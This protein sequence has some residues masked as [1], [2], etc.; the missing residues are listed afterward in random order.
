MV[1]G[2]HANDENKKNSEMW[3]NTAAVIA[4]IVI[5]SL[6][7]MGLVIAGSAIIPPP[8]G[9]DVTSSDSIRENA[10][11]FEFRH[12]LFP[13]LAHALGTLAGGFSAAMLGKSHQLRL[14]LGVAGFFLL[15]G[16][17]NTFMIPAPIW[18]NVTDLVVAYIPMGALAFYLAALLKGEVA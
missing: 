10:H 6:I 17:A 12:F 4:G 1:L 9:M 11:L 15:G 7:N 3:R 8:E 13:F 2:P 18:F 16:I 14:A 5:G